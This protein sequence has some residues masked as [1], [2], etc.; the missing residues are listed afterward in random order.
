MFTTPTYRLKI[1]NFPKEKDYNG[2]SFGRRLDYRKPL[3][4]F[5]NR[6]KIGHLA[7][8]H[9]S[10]AK[11]LKEFKDLYNVREYYFIDRQS[12]FYHDDSIE[13]HYTSF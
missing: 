6:S 5:M 12:K 8:K 4:D 1:E 10:V 9:K 13:I 3:E 7:T 2:M 11:A